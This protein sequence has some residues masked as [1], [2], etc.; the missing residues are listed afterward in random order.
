MS[1]TIA[2]TFRLSVEVLAAAKP[3]PEAGIT[4]TGP[5]MGA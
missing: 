1:V 5:R 2:G 3:H 4:A